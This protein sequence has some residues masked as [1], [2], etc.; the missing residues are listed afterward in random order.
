MAIASSCLSWARL[1]SG[2]SARLNFR[3]L[4]VVHAGQ[5]VND[6]LERDR[7]DVM[8]GDEL[9]E[10]VL[11]AGDV[12][13]APGG[14]DNE[15]ER[16]LNVGLG[17]DQAGED[18]LLPGVLGA[19]PEDVHRVVLQVP[20]LRAAGKAG[21]QAA[22][23]HPL[24]LSCLAGDQQHAS[25][26]RPSLPRPAGAANVRH[27]ARNGTQA[28]VPVA[29]LP[30]RACRWRSPASPRSWQQPPAEIV[31]GADELIAAQRERNVGKQ[32]GE[33]D[34]VAALAA[35]LAVTEPSALSGAIHLAG[36]L[37]VLE[38]VNGAWHEPVLVGD[39][40][41]QFLE[42][43]GWCYFEHGIAHSVRVS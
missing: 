4:V 36:R 34:N 33:G 3:V 41:A 6:R 27:V 15:M 43:G 10:L 35:L 5:V 20:G 29:V 12:Q 17:R 23:E 24:S 18:N 30:R 1:G 39:E 13:D 25:E 21:E 9:G 26:W 37:R 7:P 40:S 2:A 11:V 38:R 31:Q 32:R 22:G 16:A 8:G 42:V 14:V 28:N 19:D